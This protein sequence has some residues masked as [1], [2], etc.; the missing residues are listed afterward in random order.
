MKEVAAEDRRA[1]DELVSQIVGAFGRVPDP[2]QS[3]TIE[4]LC[5]TL[6]RGRRL[7]ARGQS[8]LCERQLAERLLGHLGLSD[9][10]PELAEA[11][12]A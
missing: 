6:V 11:A 7:R 3:A 12:V 1:F 2:L 5:A 8:D 4:L 9:P 10:S